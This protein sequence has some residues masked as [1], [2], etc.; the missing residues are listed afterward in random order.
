M[1]NSINTITE[2]TPT[3][4]FYESLIY[5]F[6]TLDETDVNNIKL[7]AIKNY[8]NRIMEFISIVK[9]NHII[10]KIVQTHN[11][12]RSRCSK[13]IYK[14]GDMVMLD[15]TNIRRRITRNDRSAKLFSC[16]L[17][18]FKIIRTEPKISNYKLEL[19]PRIDFTSIHPNFH[20]NLLHSYIP[21]DSEQFPKR[22]PA[23]PDPAIPD[24]LKDS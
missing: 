9:D 1:N 17:G 12:N 21:N 15:S 7:S 10:V 20:S 22:E 19:L 13:S 8:I 5:L 2:L 4:L 23:R 16:F 18:P 24:D 14:V 3:E 6:P 11:V